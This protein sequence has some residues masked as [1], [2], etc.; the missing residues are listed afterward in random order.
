MQFVVQREVIF[1]MRHFYSRNAGRRIE[2]R[3]AAAVE[4]ALVVPVLVA[5]VIGAPDVSQFLNVGQTVS[6]ASREGA[7]RASD[8]SVSDV[9][10]VVTTV[11][12]Y[13]AAS[14]PNLSS[15]QVNSATTITVR[16]SAG[17]TI[18]GSGLNSVASGATIS[19]EVSLTYNS[20]RW[21]SGFPGLN[22]KSITTKTFMRRE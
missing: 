17:S 16:D 1:Q 21:I 3:G 14:F 19:V 13:V 7:R 2:R 22:G 18:S 4:F 9:S 11:R 15:T 5:V 10:T 12:N 8:S 6:N 20:V